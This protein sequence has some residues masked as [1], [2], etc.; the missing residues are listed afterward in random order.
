M[1]YGTA[2]V[3]CLWL[4]IS[5]IFAQTGTK[6]DGLE[7]TSYRIVTPTDT[8]EYLHIGNPDSLRPT[9]VFLQGSLPR[10]LVFDFGNFKHINLPFNYRKLIQNYHLIVI[11]MPNTPVVAQKTQ[12]NAQYCFVPDTAQP[13]IFSAA[14]LRNNRLEH[15]VTRVNLVLEDWS[16]K[17]W[18]DT[19]RLHLI[20]HS[21]GA[22]IAAVVAAQNKRVSTVSLL[23]FNAYGR[24]DQLIR[25]ERAQLKSGK[26]SGSEYQDNIQA[27]YAAWKDINHTP[28]DFHNGH[29]AWTSFS[30]DYRPYLLQI[31]SPIFVGFG[32]EDLIAENCDLLPLDFISNDKS[33]LTLQPYPGWDHNF[34]EVHNGKP[35]RKNGAHFGDV[36]DDIV[37]WIKN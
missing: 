14:Y 18:V 13:T 19:N 2:L 7:A 31:D 32:T 9:L 4:C 21:Q 37:G 36:I 28:N 1:K 5:Q 3:V 6:I 25:Q 33:N 34:F 8:V 22:K 26:L 29:N 35:D 15:Y 17:E 23:G 27:H 16:Q 10:P 20:G 11:A 24:Y 30:I 12:L